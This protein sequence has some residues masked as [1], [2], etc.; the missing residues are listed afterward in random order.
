MMRLAL[1]RLRTTAHRFHGAAGGVAAIETALALPFLVALGFGAFEFGSAFYNT[2]LIQT[3]VRDAT[4][5]L[6]RA[7]DP[8]AAEENARRLAVTGS[9]NSGSPARVKWWQTQ[10]VSISYRN[11]ANPRDPATGLRDY[12]GDDTITIV[13]VSTTVT[14]G[15]L[16][17]LAALGLGNPQITAAHEE[18]HVGQ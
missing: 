2:Q 17:M 8:T 3:G 14:Y 11:E 6:A 10:H 5:Y 18:R 15:G 13:R 1:P 7:A 16:G 9:I 12:R 4:R